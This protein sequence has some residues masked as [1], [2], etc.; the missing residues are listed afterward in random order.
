MSYRFADCVLDPENREIRRGGA[1][2]D[3]EPQVF[4]L[5]LHLVENRD[6]AVS[7]DEL[8][9]TVWRGRIVADATIASRIAAARRVVGDS[10]EAQ[11]VIRTL[12]GYGFRF[13]A[14]VAVAGAGRLI[15]SKALVQQVRYCTAADGARIAYAL[16]G[17]GPPVVKTASWL[18]HLEFDL[19]SPVWRDVFWRLAQRHELIRY[20]TRGVGMS[21]EDV[22]DVDF[23]SMVEDFE[24]VIRATDRPRFAMI[25]IS[26]GAAVAIDYAVRYPERVSRLVLW[27][28]F[29]RG[30]RRRGESNQADESRAFETLARGWGKNE[31]AFLRM[32]AA[33][34]LP[35]ATAEQIGWWTELQRMATSPEH[36]ARIRAAIDDIDVSS[37]LPQVRTPTL[38]LHSRGDAA[39][40]AREAQRMAAAIPGARFVELASSNHL[41]MPQEAAWH[42]A[43]TEIESFLEDSGA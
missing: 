27:G 26:Q 19:E 6:R 8:I 20:D 39:V 23:A 12:H 35:D 21:G 42:R 25:G 16:A 37:Q 4:E 10:G 29:A 22:A 11:K 14:D 34:Y 38:V 41:V 31:S 1:P 18:N 2:I 5:L 40:P 17:E 33:L 24:A 32:F 9:E 28:G 13:V 36:A 15:P 43:M 7:K 3:H 30:R